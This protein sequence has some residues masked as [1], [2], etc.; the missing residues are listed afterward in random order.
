MPLRR[1]LPTEHHVDLPSPTRYFLPT[2]RLD[3]SKP[4]PDATNSLWALSKAVA[5]SDLDPALRELVAVSVS[6]PNGCAQ[7][8]S[9]HWKKALAAGVPEEHLRLVAAVVRHLGEQT[10]MH[11]VYHIILMNAWNRVSITI[12]LTPPG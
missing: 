11:L 7:C 3:Y 1:S 5:D 10:A 12:G 8:I 9:I 2:M 4:A 6:L